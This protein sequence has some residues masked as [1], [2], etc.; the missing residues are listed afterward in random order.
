M[1]FYPNGKYSKK[2]LADI[3]DTLEL[4]VADMN[5]KQLYTPLADISER[6]EFNRFLTELRTIISKV[7][8][9]DKAKPLRLINQLGEGY[10]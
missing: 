9:I 3:T 5:D 2:A 8:D 6:A 7:A 1:N 10:K 4:S